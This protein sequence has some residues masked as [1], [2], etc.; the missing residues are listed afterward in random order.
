MNHAGYESPLRKL[1]CKERGKQLRPS[2][3][4]YETELGGFAYRYIHTRAATHGYKMPTCSLCDKISC[5][6][7]RGPG[8]SKIWFLVAPRQCKSWS[9]RRHDAVT[10]TD[11]RCVYLENVIER[12]EQSQLETPPWQRIWSIRLWQTQMQWKRKLEKSASHERWRIK[13]NSN[14]WQ[15]HKLVVLFFN[16]IYCSE[17]LITS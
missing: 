13:N 6:C 16:S 3:H 10:Q 15:L 5:R 4:I 2:P 11:K 17:H 8:D 14:A 12:V 7:T 1:G 9:K